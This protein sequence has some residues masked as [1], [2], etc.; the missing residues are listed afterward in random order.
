[1]AVDISAITSQFSASAVIPNVLVVVGALAACYAW[2][3]AMGITLTAIRGEFSRFENGKY[4]RR[5]YQRE[6][7]NRQYRSWKK[8]KGRP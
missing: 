5:R 1:M 6:L 8:L 7:R 4:F 3:R 2:G